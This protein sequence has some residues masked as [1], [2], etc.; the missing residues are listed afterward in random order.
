M[1]VAVTGVVT[2]AIDYVAATWGVRVSA[3]TDSDITPDDTTIRIEWRSFSDAEE[4]ADHTYGIRAYE[5]SH[6]PHSRA[7][8]CEKCVDVAEIISGRSAQ[9]RSE[10]VCATDV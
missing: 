7:T 9:D 10:L 5:A 2:D 6:L 1:V 8:T 3:H 4:H